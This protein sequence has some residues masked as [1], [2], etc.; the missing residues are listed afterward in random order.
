MTAT[1]RASARQAER[2]IGRL[3][4]RIT[5]ASVA[6]LVVGVALLI[7]AGI[8]PVSGGP[9]MDPGRLVSD[10]VGLK[11]AGFLWLGL[12]AVIA[13]PVSRV[14]VALVAYVRDEDW[15][16]VGVSTAILLV[17]AIA[18]SSAVVSTV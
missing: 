9:R 12:L 18:I 4:T 16:M 13:A 14:T 6:L 1:G 2:L 17:I 7:V 10:L 5:Y 3:L 8:S 11:P 15:L